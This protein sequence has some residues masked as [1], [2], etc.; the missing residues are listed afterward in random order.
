MENQIKTITKQANGDLRVVFESGQEC[1][2]N[3]ADALFQTFAVWAMM[4]PAGNT[5]PYQHRIG[6]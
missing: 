6:D 1:T 3:K 5:A 4:H 2:I